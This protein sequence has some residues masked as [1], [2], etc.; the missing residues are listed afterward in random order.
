MA[1]PLCV[2]ISVFQGTSID[3]KAYVA[4]A[5][6]WDGISR[7]I[8]RSSY[9]S[10]GLRDAGFESHW[11]GAVAAGCDVI[12]L[13]HYAYP[14]FNKGTQ[15]AINEANSQFGIIGNRLRPNDFIMLDWEEETPEA[16]AV[17]AY[18]W[19]SR[20]R[21]NFGGR[22][23]RIYVDPSFAAAHCQDSRL[24]QFPLILANWTFDPNST[25]PA[26]KPW[27]TY[28]YLQWSD[29]GTVP[30]IPGNVDMDVFEH[31]VITP[32]TIAG[33]AG[34]GGDGM[35]LVQNP[36]NELRLDLV[37]VGT[38]GNLWH[39]WNN[40]DGLAGLAK[41]A[42]SRVESWGN[43]GTK[44]APLTAAATWD[45]KG[46]YL[47]VVAATPDGAIWAQV[48]QISGH[49]VIGWTRVTGQ[50]VLLPSGSDDASIKT[51]LSTLESLVAKIKA[52]FA[53]QS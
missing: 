8:M 1:R 6:Q 21:S 17:W 18:T 38:D 48:R 42:P 32:T 39:N 29:R 4:W 30:G 27:S 3:W 7:V 46:D 9:G 33:F 12:G 28:E 20:Q 2:D 19:L 5:R 22:V 13:Y 16:T 11:S 45:V 52:I 49:Q 15:G 31:Q 34:T 25:P 51:R 36:A 24:T 40:N 23:P 43:P 44:F 35:A 26:P 37:Y 50:E 47:N 14:D 53:Q 41:D 10:G